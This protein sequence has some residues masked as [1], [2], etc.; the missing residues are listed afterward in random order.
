M[1]QNKN[2]I[3][4]LCGLYACMR[5]KD[6]QFIH[7]MQTINDHQCQCRVNSRGW[8]DDPEGGRVS[9]FG[10][11]SWLDNTARIMSVSV[12]SLLISSL[13]WRFFSSNS[14]TIFFNSPDACRLFWRNFLAAR[15]FCSFLL[16][17]LSISNGSSGG[18]FWT[19]FGSSSKVKSFPSSKHFFWILHLS[20]VFRSGVS[21]PVCSASIVADSN[22]SSSSPS[23]RLP[24]SEISSNSITSGRQCQ[25]KTGPPSLEFEK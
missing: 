16:S 17:S 5:W 8:S 22:S 13:S 21:F 6:W 24:Q 15:R 7:N 25:E 3:T 18:L 10:E 23:S 20:S 12:S 11:H 4:H 9:G 19:I 14:T 2:W 1:T